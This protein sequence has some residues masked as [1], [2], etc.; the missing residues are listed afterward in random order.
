MDVTVVNQTLLLLHTKGN[1]FVR[2]H[3]QSKSHNWFLVTIK[4]HQ[5]IERTAHTEDKAIYQALFPLNRESA[6]CRGLQWWETALCE[7]NPLPL[8]TLCFI[9]EQ[10]YRRIKK[11]KVVSR[12]FRF[13]LL[14]FDNSSPLLKS[15]L[16]SRF[17]S[18]KGDVEEGYQTGKQDVRVLSGLCSCYYSFIVFSF[19]LRGVYAQ[20]LGVYMH[21]KFEVKVKLKYIPSHF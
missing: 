1:P 18:W 16:R 11:L 6:A 10:L 15:E 21:E 9:S 2:K 14:T 8:Y 5:R 19:I 17:R 13:V 12:P 7:D 20:K 3:I 4:L